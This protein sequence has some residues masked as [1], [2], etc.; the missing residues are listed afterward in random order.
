MKIFGRTAWNTLFHHKRKEQMLEEFKVE[1][2][3]KKLR[4]NK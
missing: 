4:R 1:P 3:D 2:F